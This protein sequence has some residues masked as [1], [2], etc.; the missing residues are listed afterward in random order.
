[1]LKPTNATTHQTSDSEAPSILIVDDDPDLL[2]AMRRSLQRHGYHVVTS[3]GGS[4]ALSRLAEETFAVV[5]SDVQMPGIGGV[6]L[7][8]ELRAR[9]I[10]VPVVLM[11]G[12]PQFEAVAS[13]IEHR[14]FRF[15]IKPFPEA[16]LVEVIAQAINSSPDAALSRALASLRV[17]FAPI[18]RSAD[19]SVYG[20]TVRVH[21]AEPTLPDL[22]ALLENAGRQQ[23]LHS[24]GQAVRD[25]VAHAIDSTEGDGCFFVRLHPEDLRDPKLYDASAPLSRCATRVVLEAPLTGSVHSLTNARASVTELRGLGFRIALDD[26][27]AGYAAL[28]SLA[29]VDP[30]FLEL[31]G[32]LVHDAH[33]SPARQQILSLLVSLGRELGSLT[34]ANGVEKKEERDLLVSLGCDLLRG[35]YFDQPGEATSAL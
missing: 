20:R 6:K 27:G 31:D 15:L 34:L 19:G 32:S 17:T 24:A 7:L 33:E 10:D 9:H 14:A 13:A 16:R 21:T 8:Q 1:V 28:T 25:F 12:D 3:N 23:R 5:L 30:E 4:E 2:A 29:A 11:T 22:S 35:K 18:F 26:L